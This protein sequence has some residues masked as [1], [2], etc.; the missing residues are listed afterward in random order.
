MLLKN[1]IISRAPALLL[2]LNC[3]FLLSGNT[4]VTAQGN[5]QTRAEK[6]TE[7]GEV[8]NGVVIMQDDTIRTGQYRNAL[9]PFQNKQSGVPDWLMEQKID[10]QVSSDIT[11]I[12]IRNFV[13]EE[14]RRDFVQAWLKETEVATLTAQNDSLRKIYASSSDDQKQELTARILKN[15]S[16][17]I[18]LNEEIPRL[19]QQARDIENAYWQ[20]APKE[21]ISRFQ[22]KIS[23]ATDS[24]Q[25]IGELVRLKQHQTAVPDT[26]ILPKPA[27]SAPK[28]GQA[29]TT[30]IVYKIQVAAAKIKLPVAETRLIKKISVIRQIENYQDE[31]GVTIY[32]TGN[33]K[34]WKEAETL[35]KQVRQEG[36]RNP[37][38]IAFKDGKRIAVN[39]ARKITNEL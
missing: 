26:L 33:L 21:Q 14:A 9:P 35:Q 4:P 34:T 37:V 32:T 39:D 1:H 3:A 20:Q 5:H 23:R 15:E 19:Y 31:K 7:F 36:V 29:Q 18:A 12:N 22:K 25:R 27:I 17:T 6:G 38:I 16:Q 24:L 2:I 30:G 10:F 28:D 13:R 11:Y 8:V